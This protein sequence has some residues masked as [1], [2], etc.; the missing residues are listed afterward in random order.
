MD[1][2][3]VP[4][5]RVYG[6]KNSVG[7]IAPEHFC[8]LQVPVFSNH[9]LCENRETAYAVSLQLFSP[10]RH[11]GVAFLGARF[12][13]L[14]FLVIVRLLDP[15][16]KIDLAQI[17][18]AAFRRTGYRLPPESCVSATQAMAGRIFFAAYA[19]SHHRSCHYATRLS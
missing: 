1:V 16:G 6:W 12:T 7:S 2:G 14:L 3:S 9:H 17:F 4:F 13:R 5:W 15:S 8:L 10:L 11:V 18:R 19:A